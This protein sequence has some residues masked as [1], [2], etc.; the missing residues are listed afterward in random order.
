MASSINEITLKSNR[1]IFIDRPPDEASRGKYIYFSNYYLK[2]VIGTNK[3]SDSFKF[4]F[5]GNEF[6]NHTSILLP[7]EIKEDVAK[8]ITSILEKISKLD[9]N[10]TEI[11]NLDISL[12]SRLHYEPYLA[13]SEYGEWKEK[14]EALRLETNI[15]ESKLLEIKPTNYS[16]IKDEKIRYGVLFTN[17]AQ[18]RQFLKY[19]GYWYMNAPQ[20]VSF[21]NRKKA[22]AAAA[23]AAA[24]EAAAAEAAAAEAAAAEAA[25]AEAAAPNAASP[26][27]ASPNAAS[28]NAASPNAASPNA[29]SP[30]KDAE[31]GKKTT[32][33]RR[34]KA[35]YNKHRK[36][37]RRR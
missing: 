12:Y 30:K 5:T 28:P 32:T 2:K 26:N 37:N 21:D 27:A 22:E 6:M 3:V 19:N 24:A 13:A 20:K 25:A 11:N 9:V 33:R 8:E 34:S 35:D 15:A 10:N 23:E 17:I 29:A 18:V 4:K 36:S 31:G 7:N 1:C 16:A 14:N